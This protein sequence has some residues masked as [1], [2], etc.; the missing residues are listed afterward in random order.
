[1]NRLTQLI[2]ATALCAFSGTASAGL[3]LAG[4]WNG[5]VGLSVDGIGS[6]STPVGQ[7][8]AM[9]PVGATILQAYLYSAGTPSPWYAD[10]PTSLAAYNGAGITLAGNAITNF[11]TLMGA[12]STR[13]EIGQWFT[14]RADV[15]SLVQSLTAGAVTTNFAWDVGEG[16]L[17]TRIDGEVL[18][19]VYSHASLP[20]GSVALLNGGQNTGGET[21]VVNLGTPLT[22]PNAAGF[23]AQLGLGI[24]FSC[25]NQQSTVQINGTTVTDTAGGLNDGLISADGSLI[26][27]GGIG[28]DPGNNVGYA[29][30][31]ELYDL[32]PF[33]S[34]GDTSFSITTNNPTNDDNIFFTSLYLTG[35]ITDVRPA[36]P[37]PET[38]ALMLAGLGLVA[39]MARRRRRG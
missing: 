32:R 1:M 6:N 2:G 26:T 7:V 33:L 15:T 14:A 37:E 16:S 11:D 36:I 23:A 34:T 18:A 38:Y 19:I 21:S 20:M 24:S 28:D 12:T 31:D 9:I 30:D 8:Q 25:C 10:S 4:S 3:T 17:N 27:V 29:T 13:P 39:A 5:N 22:D 35:Q